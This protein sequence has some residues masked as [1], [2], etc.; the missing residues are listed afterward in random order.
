MS[1]EWHQSFIPERSGEWSDVAFDAVGVIGMVFLL[2]KSLDWE[3]SP[4]KDWLL[5]TDGE[6]QVEPRSETPA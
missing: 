5:G 4:L 2:R 6:R 3:P 1:D